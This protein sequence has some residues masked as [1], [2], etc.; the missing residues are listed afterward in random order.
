MLDTVGYIKQLENLGCGK[1]LSI[2][3]Y[4]FSGTSKLYRD[5]KTNV[6]LWVVIGRNTCSGLNW[7]VLGCWQNNLPL[8]S[9]NGAFV[10]IQ[11]PL[12]CTK[13]LLFRRSSSNRVG[14]GI[15]SC[16]F[17]LCGLSSVKWAGRAGGWK[18]S[19]IL[20]FKSR[21]RVV[22]A[23]LKIPCF[24]NKFLGCFPET[25]ALIFWPF[26]CTHCGCRWQF[27]GHMNPLL[28]DDLCQPD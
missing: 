3:I 18:S 6:K 27:G 14:E 22:S 13:S 9:D 19:W 24:A 23:F 7:K 28:L 17:G 8:T 20:L 4:T 12:H 16:Q 10:S 2:H 15:G 1:I 5:R 25:G 26:L 11:N 21:G